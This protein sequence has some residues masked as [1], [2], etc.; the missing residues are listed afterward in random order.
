MRLAIFS[1]RKFLPNNAMQVPILDPFWQI[2]RNDAGG[3]DQL[4]YRQYVRNGHRYFEFTPS[5][6]ESDFA[7]LPFDY[8][9]VFL[10]PTEKSLADRLFAEAAELNKPTIV[11]ATDDACHPERWPK[12]AC[13]FRPGLYRSQQKPM[14]QAMPGWSHDLLAEDL[15]GR[16]PLRTKS[17]RP[18]VGFCGFAPPLTTAP[19]WQHFK[20]SLRL[21]ACNAGLT[22]WLPRRAGHSPRARALQLLSRSKYVDTNFILRTNSAFANP[23]GAFLPGGTLLTARRQQRDF[24]RNVIS[25]DY[26][27]CARGYSNYSIRMYETLCLGRIPVFINSDCVLPFEKEIDWRRYC[28]WVDERD[29]P[30]IGEKIAAFHEGLNPE[31]FCDLQ[32]QCRKLYEDWLSP[33]GFFHNL[34]RVLPV[35]SRERILARQD[36]ISAAINWPPE[37]PARLPESL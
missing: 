32:R 24:V 6:R 11:F 12:S 37:N 30:R 10:Q 31:E 17:S 1:H 4:N 19:G 33:D 35:E 15:G 16:L 27:L 36:P 21:A 26:V 25:S 34:H 9:R 22:R 29:L 20:D 28:V 7:V 3:H 18:R 8:G 14:E 23:T 2:V 5:L 13:V